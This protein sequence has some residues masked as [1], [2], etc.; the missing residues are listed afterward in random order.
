[1]INSHGDVQIENK[2]GQIAITDN[3]IKLLPLIL[4]SYDNITIGKEQDN[5]KSVKYEK[6]V[7]GNIYFVEVLLPR[8]NELLGKTL[9]KKKRSAATDALS[10]TTA[11]HTSEIGR[12]LVSS[13]Y[14]IR[15][16]RKCQGK[17]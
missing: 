16:N 2:R 1:M 14:K 6:K 3:D 10:K 5:V 15:Y 8:K 4:N 13:N 17:C 12:L 9:W 11:S 7:N